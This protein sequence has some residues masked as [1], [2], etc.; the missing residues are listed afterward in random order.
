MPVFVTMRGE[1]RAD[2]RSRPALIRALR[3]TAA[4]TQRRAAARA[5]AP[6]ER[7]WLMNAFATRATRREVRAIAG[8]R[9]V[10]SVRL[11]RAVGEKVPRRVR[12]AAGAEAT[13][14]PW[15]ID[16][17]DVP[18]A[19][20]LGATGAGVSV[21]IIDT[22]VDASHPALAGKVVAWRDFVAGAPT[23]TTTTATARTPSAPS[24]ARRRSGSHRARPRSS[25]R[26]WGRT[27]SGAAATCWRRRSG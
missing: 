26:R 24:S 7:F 9:A 27:G 17:I 6:V 16:A 3:R 12:I 11:D 20:R 23:P 2:G 14:E 8:D 5:G 4:R 21:G 22:G 15:G 1:V 18:A 10:R 13:G 19:R 25:P